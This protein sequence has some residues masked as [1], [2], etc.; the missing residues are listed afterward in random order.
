MVKIELTKDI[1]DLLGLI[2]V[3]KTPIG[4]E[5]LSKDLFY[6]SDV[7]QNV[8]MVWGEYDNFISGTEKS[9]EGKKWDKELEDK[10]WNVYNYI[11]DN[12]DEIISILL[13]YAKAGVNPGI[14]KRKESLNGVW[15]YTSFEKE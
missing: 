13:V 7:L 6:N 15:N 12:L 2:K 10:A 3:E 14:Y 9:F 4:V 11:I 8:L 5:I 1:I